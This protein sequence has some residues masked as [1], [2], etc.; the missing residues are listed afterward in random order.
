MLNNYYGYP[1]TW[2]TTTI[3]DTAG[4][5]CANNAINAAIGLA[6]GALVG[7]IIGGIVLLILI[8]LGIMACC[9]G[10][11]YCCVRANQ[12][13]TQGGVVLSG[14]PARAGATSV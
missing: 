1:S 7:I 5:N 3:L 8:I 12:A 13:K 14:T 6:T 10:G 9:C 11:I 4:S 2:T